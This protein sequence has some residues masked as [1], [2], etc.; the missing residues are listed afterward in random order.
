M[1]L[2]I[3]PSPSFAKNIMTSIMAGTSRNASMHARTGLPFSIDSISPLLKSFCYGLHSLIFTYPMVRNA[4]RH[5]MSTVCMENPAQSISGKKTM[6]SRKYIG[7]W[8]K[9]NN[10]SLVSLSI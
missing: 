7:H 3:G 6:V 5:I 8:R 2:G 9:K 4:K 1:K 10:P